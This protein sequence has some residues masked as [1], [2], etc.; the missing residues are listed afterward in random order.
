MHAPIRVTER[1]G[2]RLPASPAPRSPRALTAVS[3]R[4]LKNG[5]SSPRRTSAKNGVTTAINPSFTAISAIDCE[6][7]EPCRCMTTGRPARHAHQGRRPPIR[8]QLGNLYGFLNRLGQE[9]HLCV[10][11]RMST[12]FDELQLRDL[13]SFSTI[14]P[15]NCRCT[16][17]GTTTLP[18]NCTC[19]ISTASRH[20]NGHDEACQG[21]NSHGSSR[22]SQRSAT[23]G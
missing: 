20:H 7:P 18:E 11:T 15:R 13:H 17:T 23:V 19:G 1:L 3:A 5:R 8:E 16:P 22:F 2:V 4:R 21:P 6:C 14:D 9:D 10:T 12:T